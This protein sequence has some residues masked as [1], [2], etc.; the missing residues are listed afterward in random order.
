[1]LE[2][3]NSCNAWGMTCKVAS[4][5]LSLESVMSDGLALF[6]QTMFMEM[7]SRHEGD[8]EQL[9]KHMRIA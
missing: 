1:M 2:E 4:C 9:L 7:N 3:L 8:T 6:P 5:W